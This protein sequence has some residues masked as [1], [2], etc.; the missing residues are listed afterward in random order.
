MKEQ[1]MLQKF[2]LGEDQRLQNNQMIGQL[3]HDINN[4]QQMVSGFLAVLRE[5][6]GYD[7]SIKVVAAKHEVE[8]A[9]ANQVTLDQSIAD[10]EVKGMEEVK[11]LDLGDD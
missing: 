1:T 8:M 7:E 11:K 9:K 6:P 5:M 4:L 3:N 10:M 2:K